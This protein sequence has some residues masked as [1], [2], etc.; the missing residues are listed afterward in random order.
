MSAYLT[1]RFH[2]KGKDQLEFTPD[3]HADHATPLELTAA[4]VAQY[5]CDYLMRTPN[6]QRSMD[7]LGQAI[8][9]AEEKTMELFQKHKDKL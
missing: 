1:I 3:I 2:Q 9:A 5:T 7:G 6:E 4:L 8:Q